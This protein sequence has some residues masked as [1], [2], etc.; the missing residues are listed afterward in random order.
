[1]NRLAKEEDFNVDYSPEAKEK[2][3]E[4]IRQFD[5]KLSLDRDKFNFDKRKHQDNVR[6]KE[7]QINKSSS[8]A[9]SK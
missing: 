9:Q 5:K 1:M 2:L 8:K 4:D 7:K 6:L 3:L